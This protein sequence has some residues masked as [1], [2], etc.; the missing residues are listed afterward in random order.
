MAGIAL[1]KYTISMETMNKKTRVI[2][3]EE[4]LTLQ[5]NMMN[6]IHVFCES[7]CIRYS[8]AYGTLLGAVRHGGYIPWDDDIDIMMPRP[9]YMKFL[10]SFNGYKSNLRAVAVELDPNYYSPIANVYDNRTLLDES[11]MSHRNTPLGVK[12]DIYPIDAVPNDSKTQEKEFSKIFNIYMRFIVAK[13][14]SFSTLIKSNKKDIPYRLKCLALRFVSFWIPFSYFQKKI[15]GIVS[16][17]NYNDADYVSQTTF[18]PTL[19]RYP[20]EMFER[21]DLVQFEQYKFNI[22]SDYDTFLSSRYGNYME[23]PPL[24]QR[25][26]HHNFIAYWLE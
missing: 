2:S 21:Y 19:A 15:V 8:L 24:E 1:N 20:K 11:G 23:L 4:L 25:V 26:P 14:T 12:I 3:D 18:V 13:C 9:D 7:N 22:I 17:Y 16:K 10:K 5:L 6:D